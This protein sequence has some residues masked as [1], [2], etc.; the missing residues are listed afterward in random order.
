MSDTANR[1][2]LDP[3]VEFSPGPVPLMVSPPWT[4]VRGDLLV[5]RGPIEEGSLFR[6]RPVSTLRTNPTGTSRRYLE[7]SEGTSQR[8]FWEELLDRL[9]SPVGP[10]QKEPRTLGFA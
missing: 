10:F 2:D 9:R 4:C 6:G 7:V 1:G 3:G 5:G 8:S